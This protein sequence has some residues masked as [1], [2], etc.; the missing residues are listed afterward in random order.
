VCSIF[1]QSYLHSCLLNYLPYFPYL[2]LNSLGS[3]DYWIC[4]ASDM[5]SL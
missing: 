2:G 3:T 4:F 5:G 1:A